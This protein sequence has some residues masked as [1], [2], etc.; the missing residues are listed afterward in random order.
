MKYRYKTTPYPHQVRALRRLLKQGGGGLQVPMRWGKTKV[1]IDFC[2]ALFYK[3]DVRRVL[4]V[5]VT[6]G[7][8]VWEDEVAKHCPVP[9]RVIDHYAEVLSQSKHH[10]FRARQPREMN[11]YFLEFLIVNYQ[12]TYSRLQ[13]ES[14]GWAPMP[15]SVL[16]RFRPQVIIVDESHHIG[17]PTAEQSKQIRLLGAKARHRVIM[18]GS[19]FHRKP[20]YTFGQSLFYDQGKRLGTAFTAFKKRVAVFGGY[21]NYEVL[22]YRNLG[23]LMRKMREWVHIE[24]YVPPRD[25]VQNIIRFDLTGRG[26]SAYSKMYKDDVLEVEGEWVKSEIALSK[27]LRLAQIAGGFVRLPSGKYSQVGDDK[28]RTCESRLAEYMEQDI[29]KVVIGCRFIPELR[30][31]AKVGKKLGFKVILFHGA[32]PKGRER[33]RRIKLFQQYDGPCLFISQIAAG[34]ESIDLSAAS[35]MMFYSLTESYVEFDQFCKR[36]ELFDE[37]RTLMY[38]Y[39]IARGTQDQVAYDA[40]MLKQDV[41]TFMVTNPKRVERITNT[42]RSKG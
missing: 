25:P 32:V 4:V 16:Q 10:D 18:T 17:N 12:N 6:S 14:G 29:K 41:A 2:S 21:H 15:N 24:K 20:F 7:L 13:M 42:I 36:I 33:Q 37:K 39:L 11:N 26:I 35:T 38:D 1:G 5:T 9:W 23:W 8:G 28:I 3:E 27:H 31:V 30:A 22:R 40:L 34:K 19:M